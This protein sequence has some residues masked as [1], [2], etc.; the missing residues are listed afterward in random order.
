[1]H[2]TQRDFQTGFFGP[3]ARAP[4]GRR[5]DIVGAGIEG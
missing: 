2:R 5:E 1:M 4:R 3:D